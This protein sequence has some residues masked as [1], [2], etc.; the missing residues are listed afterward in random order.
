MKSRGFERT[1]LEPSWFVER[2]RGELQAQVLVEVDDWAMALRES[3]EK[4]DLD[5]FQARFTFVK[6]NLLD[7]AGVEYIGRG[8]R[9]TGGRSL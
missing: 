4:N 8:L 5:A 6:M 1:K 9:F 2:A 7:A 3:K